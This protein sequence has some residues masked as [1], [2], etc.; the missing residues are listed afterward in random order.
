MVLKWQEF[1]L[2]NSFKIYVINAIRNN[3]VFMSTIENN[4]VCL[5]NINGRLVFTKANIYIT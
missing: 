4:V 1:F 5:F 3:K 2:V